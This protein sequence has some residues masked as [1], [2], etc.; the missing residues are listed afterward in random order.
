MSAGPDI[1]IPTL[2][3]MMPE[4]PRGAL[5]R[6]LREYRL[7]HRRRRRARLYQVTWPRPGS[8]WAVDLADPP[9]LVDGTGRCLL[10][11]RDLASR[12]SIAWISLPRGNAPSISLALRRL[13]RRHGAPLVLK[14]DNGSSFLA[15]DTRLTLARHGVVHLRSPREWPQYNGA[16]EAGIGV[17]KAL[18][19]TAAATRGEPDCWTSDDLEEARARANELSRRIGNRQV[20]AAHEWAHRKRVTARLR[21]RLARL[22][23]RELKQSRSS[24]QDTGSHRARLLR[25]AIQESLLRMG[26]LEIT[27]RWVRARS[28]AAEPSSSYR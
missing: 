12:Y 17:L 10:A 16:C 9:S 26:L 4:A 7:G 24:Q 25:K 20:S 19:S 6:H 27:S 11:V 21:R 18:T 2:R 22:M 23:E 3:A 14:S 15:P 5:E 8:V 1:G 28:R 13:F